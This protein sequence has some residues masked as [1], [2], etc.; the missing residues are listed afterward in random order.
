MAVG[1][2]VGLWYFW[3]DVYRLELGEYRLDVASSIGYVGLL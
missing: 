1:I 3:V 2:L